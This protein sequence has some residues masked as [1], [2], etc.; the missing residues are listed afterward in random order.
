[1][2]Q[3]ETIIKNKVL[4]IEIKISNIE[5][6]IKKLEKCIDVC[7]K[8]GIAKIEL[9]PLFVKISELIESKKRLKGEIHNIQQTCNHEFTIIDTQNILFGEEAIVQCKKCGYTTTKMICDKNI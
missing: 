1:M 4:E 8:E 5:D 9:K 7:K 3:D 6:S 2:L